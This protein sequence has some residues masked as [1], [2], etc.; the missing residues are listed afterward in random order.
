[1][2]YY[3]SD[4]HDK[5]FKFE[6]RTGELLQVIQL[7]SRTFLRT[8]NKKKNILLVDNLCYNLAEEL[9]ADKYEVLDFIKIY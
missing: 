8:F 3:N 6:A 1:M 2:L 7:K 5:L 9:S 4:D